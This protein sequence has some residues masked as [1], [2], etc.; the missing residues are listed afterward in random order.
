MK[1]FKEFIK[2]GHIGVDTTWTDEYNGKEITIS[3]QDVNNYLDKNNVKVEEIDPM[4][5]KNLLINT[6][7]DSQRVEF[8]NL[9][10]PV[11]ITKTNGKYTKILDGQHRV[12]KCINNNI[13]RIKSRIL[14]LDTAPDEYKKIFR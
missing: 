8:A 11:I 10:Y 9:D 3:L 13:D 4:L 5:I 12:V 2:E 7:R 14:D 1:T 6:K